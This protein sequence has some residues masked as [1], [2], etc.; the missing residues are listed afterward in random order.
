M[1][2]KL[3]EHLHAGQLLGTLKVDVSSSQT[4]YQIRL[5]L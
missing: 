1:V 5:N 2:A 3:Q 4:L